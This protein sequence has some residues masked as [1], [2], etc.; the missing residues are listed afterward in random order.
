MFVGGVSQ[1]VFRGYREDRKE[2]KGK[3]ETKE[4]EGGIEFKPSRFLQKIH[5]PVSLSFRGFPDYLL[6]F[7]FLVDSAGLWLD[8]LDTVVFLSRFRLK[9]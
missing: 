4:K 5:R 6:V 3:K 2:E 9:V 7:C 1:A 8:V